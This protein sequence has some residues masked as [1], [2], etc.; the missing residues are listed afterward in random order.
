MNYVIAVHVPSSP[1]PIIGIVINHKFLLSLPGAG[2]DE[3]TRVLLVNTVFLQ[4]FIREGMT[5]CLY[6]LCICSC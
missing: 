4:L 1:G 3:L 6:D 2:R 5:S